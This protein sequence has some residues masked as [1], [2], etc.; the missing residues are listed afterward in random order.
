MTD[1]PLWVRKMHTAYLQG[2]Q[3]TIL[4][5]FADHQQELE[6]LLVAFPPKRPGLAPLE[7]QRMPFTTAG[8]ICILFELDTIYT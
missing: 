3:H 2:A 4:R 7:W 1:I 5:I 6:L 8:I